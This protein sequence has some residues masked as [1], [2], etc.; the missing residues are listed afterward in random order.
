MIAMVKEKPSAPATNRWP[1]V[2]QQRAQAKT[3][4]ERE[5]FLSGLEGNAV[6]WIEY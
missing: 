3:R 5:T 2:P 4:D 1:R 6:S